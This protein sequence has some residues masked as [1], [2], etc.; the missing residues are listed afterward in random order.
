MIQGNDSSNSTHRLVSKLVSKK[1]PALCR[2][3]IINRSDA[4]EI[5][6]FNSF[7]KKD[8]AVFSAHPQIVFQKNRSTKQ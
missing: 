5:Q 1:I 7:K 4:D 8:S 3:Q 6:F 2:G